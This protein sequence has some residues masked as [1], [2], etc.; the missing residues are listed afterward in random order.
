MVDFVLNPNINSILEPS[1]GS[2]QFIDYLN[3]VY[4]G[5]IL[6][7]EKNKDIFVNAGRDIVNFVSKCKIAHA[8][9]VISL[10]K[11]NKFI[12]VK[13]DLE[14]GFEMIQNNK[15]IPKISLPPVGMYS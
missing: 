7:I 12:L 1:C 6:G 14:K 3:E 11:E 13:E 4:S 10:H 2:G 15:K 5:Y 8:R 9:R